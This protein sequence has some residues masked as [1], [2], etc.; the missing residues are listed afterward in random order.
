[1]VAG[2]AW[3]ETVARGGL[4]GPQLEASALVGDEAGAGDGVVVAAG[5]E[6]PSEHCRGPPSQS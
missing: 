1:M 2:G 3:A 5:D 4:T 6:M